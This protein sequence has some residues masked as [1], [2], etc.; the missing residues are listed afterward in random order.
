VDADTLRSLHRY[1]AVLSVAAVVVAATAFLVQGS[2]SALALFLGLFGPLGCF[3]FV[4]AVLSQTTDYRV[5]GEEL[6]RGVAWYF[7][8]LVGWSSFV[9][10]ADAL[11]ATP[12]TVAGLPALSAL[13]LVV[14]LV[15]LRL[16]TGYDLTVR[17]SG[18]QL[19]AAAVSTLAGALVVAYLVVVRDQSVL[20]APL[21]GVAAVAGFALWARHWQSPGR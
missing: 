2:D 19:L 5:F 11:E 15:V 18:G 8:A 9:A 1:G 14:A 12:F 20:L 6:L 10:S 3:Y 7:A 21:Y 13:A 16:T 17:S 4:G